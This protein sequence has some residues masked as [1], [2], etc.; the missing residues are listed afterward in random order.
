MVD[1]TAEQLKKEFYEGLKR[2]DDQIERLGQKQDVFHGE[3]KEFKDEMKEFKDEMKGFKTNVDTFVEQTNATID[4]LEISAEKRD[5]RIAGIGERV[6]K[7]AQTVDK[8][9][10]RVDKAAQTVDKL[11]ERVDKAAQTVDK[12]GERVDKTSARVDHVARLYGES[13]NNKGLAVEDYFARYFEN[14]PYLGNIKF[15]TVGR[16][17]YSVDNYEHDIVLM[18]GDHVGII[19]VKYKV[20]PK[21]IDYLIEEELP[22]LERYFK[23]IKHTK[24]LHLGIAGF[25][26]PK[27]TEE[28]A[29]RLGLYALTRSSNETVFLN[30]ENFTPKVF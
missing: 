13:E 21:N 23:D 17:V 12:L 26:V 7:A 20:L 9:G 6:D 4:R 30:S 24:H 1:K 27:K 11:G 22:R 18:N 2:V 5:N 28:Y 10:E 16:S 15:D 25:L 8:L 3:M 19:S 29:E 14:K